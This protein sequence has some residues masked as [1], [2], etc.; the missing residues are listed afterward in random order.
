MTPAHRR[1]LLTEAGIGAAINAILS[2]VFVL[3][4]FGGRSA[5]P[6]TG[7]GGVVADAVPQSFMVALMSCLVPTLVARR[8]IARGIV[9]PR[10]AAA[11]RPRHAVLRAIVV[12]V[13]VALTAWGVQSIVLPVFG[14]EWSFAAVSVF[15][16][17]WGGALGACIAAGATWWTLSDD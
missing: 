15:K 4:V 10:T 3:L 13:P 7:S 17:F 2:L 5:V 11:V 16:C 14:R 1:Y 6:V 9:T 8:R 12:A